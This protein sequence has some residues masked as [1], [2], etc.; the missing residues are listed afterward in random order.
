MRTEVEMGMRSKDEVIQAMEQ[1]TAAAGDLCT[2]AGCPYEK[3]D[4]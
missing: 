3:E 4:D 2:C 1:H